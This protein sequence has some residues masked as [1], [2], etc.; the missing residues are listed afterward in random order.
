MNLTTGIFTSPR[1][2]IYSFSFTAQA[3]FPAT[4]CYTFLQVGFYL[5]GYFVGSGLADVANVP[6]DTQLRPV[7]FH[8]TFYLK[9]GD[10]VWLKILDSSPGVYLIDDVR[11]FT[12]FTGW[13]VEEE[14]FTINRSVE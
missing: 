8:A 13:L 1:T 3:F 12:H 4:L 14:I 11:H 10:Q 7:G 6:A 5:N 9:A 2:G